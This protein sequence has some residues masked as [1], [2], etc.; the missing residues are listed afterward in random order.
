MYPEIS[1]NDKGNH[2]KEFKRIANLGGMALIFRI[3]LVGFVFSILIFF[4]GMT[5]SFISLQN[6]LQEMTLNIEQIIKT[7]TIIYTINIITMMIANTIPFILLLKSSKIKTKS[8]FNTSYI[9]GKLVVAGAVVCLG[10]NFIVSMGTNL[11]FILLKQVFHLQPQV[12]SFTPQTTSVIEFVAFFTFVC[13]VAPFTEEFIFRGVLLATL[14]KYGDLFAIV[15][16]SI[17]FSLVH[18]NLGQIPS[19]LIIGFV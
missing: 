2:H 9:S 17:L 10:L 15:I 19:A 1:S 16:T 18:G 8:L 14:R 6:P 5:V 13:I 3:L 12:P 7:P 11:F 4:I